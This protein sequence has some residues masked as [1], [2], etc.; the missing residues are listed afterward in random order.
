MERTAAVQ[1]IDF[2]AAAPDL[3]QDRPSADRLLSGD[4]VTTVQ[5]F[6]SDVSNGFH[7][8][9]WQSTVGSWR[10][11]YSEHEFCHITSG[12]VRIHGD[13]RHWEFGPGQ[14]FVIPAGFAGVWEVLEPMSKLYVIYEPAAR[15]APNRSLDGLC[16]PV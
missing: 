13:G 12:R 15:D 5:N 3:T 11:T 4:P 6:F 14:S 2:T 10:V 1:I 9:V 7:A 8:G 16:A